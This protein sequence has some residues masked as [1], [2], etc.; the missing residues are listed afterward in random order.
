MPSRSC[1]LHNENGRSYE[2]FGELDSQFLR[3]LVR[4]WN[5]SQNGF[6]S[7][8]EGTCAVD[9]TDTFASS[10]F[11]SFD[12]DRPADG[13]RLFQALLDRR[14]TRFGVRGFW[15]DDKSTIGEFGIRDAC[16]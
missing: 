2:S 14:D 3:S 9:F 11:T 1:E 4:T 7:C 5:F 16:S 12:H 13:L 8:F 10:A 6:E 15:D